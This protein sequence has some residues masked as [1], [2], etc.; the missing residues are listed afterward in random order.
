MSATCRY[1]AAVA[2]HGNFT[3]AAEA[4]FVSQPAL[5]KQIRS[6]ERQLR[7]TLFDRHHRDLRLTRAGRELRAPRPG[8]GGELG[9]HPAGVDPGRRVLAG[10]GHAHQPGPGPAARRPRPAAV[11]LRRVRLRDA[12]DA[13]ER[14][15]PPD[16]PTGPPTP[17]S[18]G[19]PYP[20][21]P[22][23]GSRS[24][25][26]PGWWPCRGSTD[27]R[28]R[29]TV[30]MADLLDE[31][32]LALPEAAGPGPR[33]L[34][35]PRRAKRPPRTDRRHDQRHRGDL[36]GRRRWRRGLPAGGGQRARSS[37]AATSS[38]PWSAT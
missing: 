18:S 23:G 26:S 4:L 7:V 1:F 17:P 27:W 24:P 12:P 8:D 13:L 30:T 36:R 5:S 11:R 19:C 20:S 15:R 31:P 10:G 33:P 9:G 37:P 29:R 35:R 2:T 6:L 28:S 22:T 34:A 14:S 16:W 3:R 32:F 38:C 25:A 21:R